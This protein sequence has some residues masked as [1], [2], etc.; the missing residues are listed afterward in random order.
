MTGYAMRFEMCAN[1][2]AGPVIIFDDGQSKLYKH[3]LNPDTPVLV[4]VEGEIP[5]AEQI[6]MCCQLWQELYAGM[7]FRVAS[8]CP[9][10]L[11]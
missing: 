2:W 4:Q 3:R 11:Q 6:E 10:R 9:V 8:F 5:T 7:D 1:P